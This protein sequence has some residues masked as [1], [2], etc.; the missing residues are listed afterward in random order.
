LILALLL[1]G[2]DIGARIYAQ[3]QLEQRLDSSV[4][5]AQARVRISGFPFLGNLLV[6]G[7]VEKITA[8]LAHASDGLFV[9]DQVHITVTGVT[10]SRAQ[11]VQHRI[12]QIDRIDTGTVMAEMSQENFD[13]LVGLPVVFGSGVARATVGGVAVT[14][15]VSIVNNHLVASGLPLSV[16]IPALPVLPCTADVTIVPGY[17]VASCTFHQIPPALRIVP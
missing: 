6:S 4:P 1:A 14:A 7:R 12:I 17:L 5:G 2:L 15:R 11:F 16:P 3:H 10:I 13:R 9:L 8:D